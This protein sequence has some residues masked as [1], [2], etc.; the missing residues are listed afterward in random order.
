MKKIATLVLIPIF[1]YVADQWIDGK[2]FYPTRVPNFVGK[3][4]DAALREVELDKFEPD[5]LPGHFQCGT[6]PF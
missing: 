1:L 2:I 4:L 3:N 6:T 5:Q